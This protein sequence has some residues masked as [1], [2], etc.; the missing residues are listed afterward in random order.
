MALRFFGLESYFTNNG[1]LYNCS[2][3]PREYWQKRAP[4]NIGLGIFYLVSG[5]TY[6]ILYIPCLYVISQTKQ[7][8]HSCF[9]IMFF[10]GVLDVICLTINADLSG[11]FSIVGANF[12]LYPTLMFLSGSIAIGMWSGSCYCCV[13]LAVDRCIDLWKPNLKETL[14]EGS[15]IWIWLFGCVLYISY[16][17]LYDKPLIYDSLYSTWFFNPHIHNDQANLVTIY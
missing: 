13:L 17:T 9:K 16:F 15:R 3:F 11:Y 12:C 1:E 7:L 2:S 5:L 14:F 8:R 6:Q 4:Q 10:L